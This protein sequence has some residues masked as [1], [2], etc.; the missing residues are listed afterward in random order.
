LPRGKRLEVVNQLSITDHKL[1]KQN[2]KQE[3]KDDPKK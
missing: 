1:V 2:V 3:E